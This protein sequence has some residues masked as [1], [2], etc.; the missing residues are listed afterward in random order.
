MRTQ[1]CLA[2]GDGVACHEQG[3]GDSAA[4]GGR[5]CDICSGVE[6]VELAS[7]VDCGGGVGEGLEAGANARDNDP[8][9]TISNIASATRVRVCTWAEWKR[10]THL[11]TLATI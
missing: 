7:S 3:A 10:M 9:G 4:E 8:R 6:A 1:C 2:Q 11:S 5:D